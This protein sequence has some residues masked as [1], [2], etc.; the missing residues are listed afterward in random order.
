MSVQKTQAWIN[1]FA[2]ALPMGAALIAGVTALAK[3]EGVSDEE[4]NDIT[5]RAVADSEQRARERDAMSRPSADA[6]TD[7]PPSDPEE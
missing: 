5:R 6:P 1:L 2:A 4:I 7:H 3:Q